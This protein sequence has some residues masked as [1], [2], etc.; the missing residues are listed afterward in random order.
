LRNAGG[1]NRGVLAVFIARLFDWKNMKWAA[2]GLVMGVVTL[3]SGCSSL[4]FPQISNPF[5]SAATQ[6]PGQTLPAAAGQV[7]GTGPVRV[8]LLLPLSGDVASVGISMANAAQLAMEFIAR[9]PDIGENITLVIKDT[10]GSPTVASQKASE[11]IGEG[12]SLILGPLKAESVNAAG[13]VARSSGI[14]LI[15]FSNNSGAAAPGVYLLNVLPE[16]EVKRTLA[17][18]QSQGRQAFAAIVPNTAF[19]QR[20]VPA[21]G[22]RSRADGQGGL[23][24]LQRRGSAQFGGPAYSISA[25]RLD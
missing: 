17:Y 6:L 24:L 10:I 13:A 7:I 11:A 1:G 21:G 5:P 12:A 4:S 16:V 20:G 15:G 22:G 23:S 19:G 8:A 9:N 2:L 3:V 18:A 14:P 25:I